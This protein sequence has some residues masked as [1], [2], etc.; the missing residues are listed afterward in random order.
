MA[1]GLND[2]ENRIVRELAQLPPAAVQQVVGLC[3]ADDPELEEE[4]RR[5]AYLGGFNLN[6]EAQR[7]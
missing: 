3:A 4:L 1:A 2:I 7:S 6:Q 5:V